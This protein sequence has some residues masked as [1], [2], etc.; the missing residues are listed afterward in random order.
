MIAYGVI[1][2]GSRVI[3]AFSLLAIALSLCSVN[4]ESKVFN[5]CVAEVRERSDS[6]AI[7]ACFCNGG[8]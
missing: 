3:S 8:D 7:A 5:D 6:R 2:L 1:W 4:K